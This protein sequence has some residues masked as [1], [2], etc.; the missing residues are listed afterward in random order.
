[1]VEALPDDEIA[2]HICLRDLK[3]R[4]VYF[5]RKEGEVRSIYYGCVAEIE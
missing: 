3:G 5:L 2:C 4:G 1:M